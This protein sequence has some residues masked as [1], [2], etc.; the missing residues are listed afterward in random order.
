[1]RVVN[2]LELSAVSGGLNA[3]DCRTAA[4]AGFTIGAATGGIIGSAIG[5]AGPGALVGGLIVGSQAIR[6]N[7]SCLSDGVAT[8]GNNGDASGGGN[9]GTRG[10]FNYYDPAN[11]GSDNPFGDNR[12]R[13]DFG[14]GRGTNDY[15]DY[16]RLGG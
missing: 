8:G 13:N 1:M 7:S 12:F 6:N 15:S 10:G 5:L 4:M 14:R 2:D 3:S 11:D 9:T 16:L